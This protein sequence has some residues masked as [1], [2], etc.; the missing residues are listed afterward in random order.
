MEFSEAF[1]WEPYL[2]STTFA[3]CN[4]HFWSIF[5]PCNLIKIH[6][7]SRRRLF[8]YHRYLFH[9]LSWCFSGVFNTLKA[10]FVALLKI[11]W[12][13]VLKFGSLNFIT[14]RSKPIKIKRELSCLFLFILL[15]PFVNVQITPILVSL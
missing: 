12:R 13:Y 11:Y 6:R 1:E 9:L 5:S 15:L 10:L 14:C 7:F 4:A 3:V 8:L 2:L